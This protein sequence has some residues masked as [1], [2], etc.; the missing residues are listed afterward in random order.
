[1]KDVLLTYFIANGQL[2]LP[3]I[4][5]FKIEVNHASYSNNE[6]LPMHYAIQFNNEKGNVRL[7]QFQYLSN[8]LD[9]SIDQIKIE[10]EQF[11]N[12]I[13]EK[14]RFDLGNFGFIFFTN[15]EF[16]FNNNFNTTDYQ[17]SIAFNLQ[18]NIELIENVK[19]DNQWIWWLIG[20]SSIALLAI[21]L[22]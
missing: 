13:I 10:L 1:M 14:G 4:G 5:S 11:S 22:K 3:N 9:K 19:I 15:N 16:Q 12:E 20:L 21:Y 7:H 2:D 17:Q 18:N 8:I 6:M